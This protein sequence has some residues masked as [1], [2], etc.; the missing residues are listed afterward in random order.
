MYAVLFTKSRRMRWAGHV[1]R[2]GR[3]EKHMQRKYS[4]YL[5]G[6]VHSGDLGM[7]EWNGLIWLIIGTSKGDITADLGVS[8]W[9]GFIWLSTGPSRGVVYTTINFKSHN[10]W[11]PL[12]KGSFIHYKLYTEPW[13]SGCANFA[14][15]S[16]SNR[17]NV[18][19]SLV[20]HF[21]TSWNRTLENY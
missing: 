8:E 11:E 10:S 17:L 4:R 6:R 20:V 5:E 18:F 16:K 14:L 9:N 13:F 7:R 15:T 12:H 19:W 21:A 3:R 2:M 1:A